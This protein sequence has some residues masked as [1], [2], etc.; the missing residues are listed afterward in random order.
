VDT[1]INE[2]AAASQVDGSMRLVVVQRI[3]EEAEDCGSPIT[4]TASP[5][6]WIAMAMCAPIMC[7]WC[8]LWGIVVNQMTV[9]QAS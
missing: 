2:I 1:V 8:G 6:R 3:V 5:G 9:Q 4:R 7:E